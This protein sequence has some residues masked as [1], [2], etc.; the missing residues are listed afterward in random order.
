MLSLCS[1]QMCPLLA[2]DIRCVTCF[3]S[4]KVDSLLKILW[5]FV[6]CRRDGYMKR[7]KSRKLALISTQRQTSKTD[8][9]G[10]SD[11]FT[12]RQTLVHVFCVKTAVT[13]LVWWWKGQK[14]LG[15][16]IATDSLCLYLFI[17]GIVVSS[18]RLCIHTNIISQYDRFEGYSGIKD[19]NH[20]YSPQINLLLLVQVCCEMQCSPWNRA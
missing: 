17:W 4:N 1:A 18:V 19:Q 13:L 9:I 20:H 7:L 14:T 6:C 3:A 15:Y 12:S 10:D 2:T 5:L 8:V 16:I 11:S